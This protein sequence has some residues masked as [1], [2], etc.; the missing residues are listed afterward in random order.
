MNVKETGFHSIYVLPNQSSNNHIK[1]KS[2]SGISS[3]STAFL[4]SSTTEVGSYAVPPASLVC[5]FM[6]GG[7]GVYD[8][9]K[10][11]WDFL[12]EMVVVFIIM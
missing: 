3:T 8:I 9:R 12:R 7:V 1:K 11:H 10:R 6:D 5:V 2:T 4:P